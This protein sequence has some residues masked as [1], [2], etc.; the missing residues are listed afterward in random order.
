MDISASSIKVVELSRKGRL[1]HSYRLERYV[2]EPMPVD[3]LQDGGINQI[4][5]VSECL[6]RAVKR[7]GARQKNCH[8]IAA[9]FCHYQENQRSRRFA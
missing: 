8:G 1:P 9:D 3:A 4:E 6:R 7:M 5:Q 2:I